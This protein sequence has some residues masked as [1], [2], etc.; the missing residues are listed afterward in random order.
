MINKPKSRLRTIVLTVGAFGILVGSGMIG[1][2]LFKT[3]MDHP[4]VKKINTGALLS[5]V[6][7][8][9]GLSDEDIDE[10]TVSD[11]LIDAYR[12]DDDLPRVLRIDKIGV[13]ARILPMDVT[14]S[15][16]IQAPE[17]IFDSGWY[18][19]GARPGTPGM[20]FIDAHASGATREGLFAYIDVLRY[21]DEITVEMGDGEILRYEVREV[22]IANL[23]D[24]DMAEVLGLRRGIKEGLVL[25]TCTGKWM[26]DAR[27]YNQRVVVYAE[28]V[29]V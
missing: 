18:K 2:G 25:M 17:N 6:G 15:N 20:S 11:E 23:N 27:T 14:K 19:G 13:K 8:G 21:S 16:E 29:R 12:V 1:Y 4:D 22:E 5:I 9:K 26:A 7:Q 10:T 28:R 24:I 3:F